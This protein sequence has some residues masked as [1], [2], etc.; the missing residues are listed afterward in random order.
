MDKSIALQLLKLRLGIFSNAR[1]TYLNHLLDTTI[2]M[3]TDEKKI[4]VGLS[5][6]VILNFVVS[7]SA[8]LFESKGEQGGMP[9]HL[10]F[11]L[12]NLMMHNGATQAVEEDV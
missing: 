1:D 2:H 8:W 9:R 11:S 10:Q 6:P 5:N 4:D 12:H 7:Y 3:L